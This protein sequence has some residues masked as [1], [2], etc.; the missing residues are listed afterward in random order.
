MLRLNLRG[1]RRQ[2]AIEQFSLGKSMNFHVESALQEFKRACWLQPSLLKMFLEIQ[3]EVAMAEGHLSGAKRVAMR[4][5]FQVCGVSASVFDQFERQS[6]AGRSYQ[7]Y[8]YNQQRADPKAQLKD[9]YSLLEVTT[10]ATDAEVK[11]AYR[12][13][14]SKHHP[15]R[16]MAKGVPPEMIKLANQKT[17]QIKEAYEYIKQARGIS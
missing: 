7:S 1:E 4:H 14:M 12:R 13:M 16:M 8:T 10:S 5:V 15:D 2:R 11:K 6:Q 17:Q 3:V 9:A